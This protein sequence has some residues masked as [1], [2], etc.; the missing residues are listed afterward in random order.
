M[1][2]YV[3]YC[4]LNEEEILKRITQEEIA[5][6]ILGYKPIMYQWIKSPI[7]LRRNGDNTPGARF[8]MWNGKLFFIDFGDQPTHRIIF[9]FVA[10]YYNVRFFEALRIINEYFQLG[11]GNEGEIR[12]PKPVIN[13]Q[14]N[15]E[16]K[17]EKQR[18]DIIYKPKP[19]SPTD[20]KI[21]MPYEISRNNLIEDEV[22]AIVWYKFWSFTQNKLI[23]MRPTDPTYAFTEFK[24]R[25][26]IYKPLSKFKLGKFITNC[27]E[28]DIGGYDKLPVSGY[29][30]IIKK[31]YKDY[32]II[33]NQNLPNT[34]WFQ[35]EGCVPKQEILI[36]LCER[37]EYIYIFFDNDEAGI[38]A[39]FKLANEFNKLY[40]NKAL[41]IWLPENFLPQGI[42]DPG[43]MM[44]KG[45]KR[46]LQQFLREK[47]FY[48]HS[49][50][51][52]SI[53]DTPSDSPF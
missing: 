18:T 23:V 13:H 10:D 37:F 42:K 7:K 43:N 30:L 22:V 52:T 14:S 5:E 16:V 12:I 24:G 41:P 33:K 20:K 11:L 49:S 15:P 47:G 48:E 6:M 50:N 36:D 35:N 32:R 26:K 44:E 40:L 34:I 25:V 27:S 3:D 45:K 51:H 53:V 29:K 8:E 2:E 38:N 9:K 39:A 31:S 4:P 17:F 46:E 21:W 19:F 28:N 1:Y